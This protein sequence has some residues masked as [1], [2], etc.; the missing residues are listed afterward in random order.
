MTPMATPLK[1][2]VLSLSSPPSMAAARA[3]TMSPGPRAIAPNWTM[4]RVGPTRMADTPAKSPASAQ[5]VKEMAREGTPHS[6]AASRFSA[7]ARLARPT[8]V[9]R[10]KIARPIV[11]RGTV[12]STS[13]NCAPTRRLPMVTLARTATEGRPWKFL[14]VPGGRRRRRRAAPAPA[15]EHHEPWRSGQAPDDDDLG[16]RAGPDRRGQGD[17]QR[18]PVAHSVRQHQDGKDLGGED[19]HLAVGEVED[20][21]TCRR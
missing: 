8:R 6:S 16:Q 20:A 4:G 18:Q 7:D 10:K 19:T 21:T 15:I 9:V 3:R 11:S 14:P 2:T 12:K 17:R 1:N 5:M 13:R